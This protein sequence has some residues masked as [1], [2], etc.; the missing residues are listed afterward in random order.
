MILTNVLE[1]VAQQ[2]MRERT[3]EAGGPYPQECPFSRLVP[4]PERPWEHGWKTVCV[5]GGGGT[6]W[7]ESEGKIAILNIPI[8]VLSCC[9]V[10]FKYIMP[11]Q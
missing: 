6:G 9:S 11:D 10:I 1:T 2:V 5:S 4:S 7:K 3:L 8:F